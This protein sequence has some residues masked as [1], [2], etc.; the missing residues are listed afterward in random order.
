MVND[1]T[2][3]AIGLQTIRGILIFLNS[4]TIKSLSQ[5]TICRYSLQN[6]NRPTKKMIKHV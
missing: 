3:C 1:V 4:I 2:F 6:D 5:K